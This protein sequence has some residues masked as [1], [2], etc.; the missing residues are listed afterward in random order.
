MVQLHVDLFVE[1]CLAGA[2]GNAAEV[3]RIVCRG[4]Y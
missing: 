2:N 4:E 1:V 3:S